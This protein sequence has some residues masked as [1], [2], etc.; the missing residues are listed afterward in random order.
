LLNAPCYL[1]LALVG[2]YYPE[3]TAQGSY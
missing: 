2:R 3:K 1:D